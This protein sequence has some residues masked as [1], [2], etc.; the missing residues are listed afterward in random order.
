MR[1]H[2]SP[3]QILQTSKAGDCRETHIYS[4]K[5][6]ERIIVRWKPDDQQVLS[7]KAVHSDHQFNRTTVR[8][9]HDFRCYIKRGI[10]S[11]FKHFKQQS[12]T[13]SIS[14]CDRCNH[15]CDKRRRIN[16]IMDFPQSNFMDALLCIHRLRSRWYLQ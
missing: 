13:G 16:Y 2:R 10:Q 1:L 9:N 14:G 3:L 15:H 6:Y 11:F 5:I 8:N 4:R 12:T 7:L